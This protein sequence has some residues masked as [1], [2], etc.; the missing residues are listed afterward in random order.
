[1]SRIASRDLALAIVLDDEGLVIA[2]C[3]TSC[4]NKSNN[5]GRGVAGEADLAALHRQLADRQG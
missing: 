5:K 1:M 3:G 2:D 4:T